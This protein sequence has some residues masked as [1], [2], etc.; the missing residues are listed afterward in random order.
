MFPILRP[1]T[2]ATQTRII[3]ETKKTIGG[4]TNMRKAIISITILTALL[5]FSPAFSEPRTGYVSDML[6]LTF[7]EG[8]GN[9]FTVMKTLPSNTQLTVLSEEEKYMKVQLKSGDVGWVQKQFI[10]FSPPK[11]I[12]ID[13]LT[14]TNMALEK[15]IISMTTQIKELKTSMASSPKK[16]SQPTK[17]LDKAIAELNQKNKNL[18]LELKKTKDQYNQLV[19]QSGNVHQLITENKSLV[20]ENK[21]FA[22]DMALLKEENSD[23]F[24]TAMIKWFLAGVGVL[25]VGWL[26]GQSIS[27]RRRRGNTLLD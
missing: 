10:M 16:R 15:K 27:S 12:Q 6:L 26:I 21:K 23:R 17:N 22:H 4:N 18:S 9:D 14:R 1:L 19:S 11:S 7:R 8:P 24:Q 25:L 3:I 2:V 20:S 5:Q 13:K